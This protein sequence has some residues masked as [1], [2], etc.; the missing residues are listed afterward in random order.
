MGRNVAYIDSPC[1]DF[2][3]ETERGTLAILSIINSP[4][5]KASYQVKKTP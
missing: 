1:A 2:T 3:I 5:D 4:Q